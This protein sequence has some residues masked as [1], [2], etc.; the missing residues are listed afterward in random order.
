VAQRDGHRGSPVD[1]FLYEDLKWPHT[2]INASV[3]IAR[4]DITMTG[5]TYDEMRPGCYDPAARLDDMDANWVEASLCFPSFPRFCGRTF[6]EAADK[7]LAMLCVKA[8]DDWM[9]AT[10]PV[11]R[12]RSRERSR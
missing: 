4:E 5:M 8:H 6:H 10:G 9:V 2:R 11:N 1:W 3:G 12:S 7:E